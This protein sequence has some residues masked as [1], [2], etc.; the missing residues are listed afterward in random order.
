M[1]TFYTF[2][3]WGLNSISKLAM[4]QSMIEYSRLSKPNFIAPLGDNFYE[5]GVKSVSDPKWNSI[6]RTRFDSYYLR[7]PWFPVLGNHDYI[8]N[9]NAQIQYRDQRWQM[10]SKYYS[11][12]GPNVLFVFIDT[13]IL[14]PGETALYLSRGDMINKGVDTFNKQVHLQWIENTLKNSNAKWK[15]VFGHY[16][17]YSDGEHGNTQE[18][19]QVLPLLF[20]KY[21]V[22]AYFSGHDH[23]FQYHWVDGTSYFVTGCVSKMGVVTPKATLLSYSL[24]PGFI[25]ATI[26]QNTLIVKYI[27][28]RGKKM[29]THITK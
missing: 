9:P 27:T 4:E 19:V 17:I 6:F 24:E 21:N 28:N 5:V 18:L 16:P 11:K 29:T 20:K 14:A 26:A 3:D 23:S 7:C 13:V 25:A 22:D 1:I 8:G 10:P 2:G 12:Q 15:I